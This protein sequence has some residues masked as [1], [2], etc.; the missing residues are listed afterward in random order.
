MCDLLNLHIVKAISVK[1]RNSSANEFNKSIRNSRN[2]KNIFRGFKE[3]GYEND[4]KRFI[5]KT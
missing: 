3:I 1:R 4:D 2:S 5:K